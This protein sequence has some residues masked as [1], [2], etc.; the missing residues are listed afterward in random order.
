M[1]RLQLIVILLFAALFAVFPSRI[2][3]FFSNAPAAFTLLGL[4]L[5]LLAH[6]LRRRFSKTDHEN[7]HIIGQR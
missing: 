5:I 4:S 2:V 6:H 3:A 1:T 7:N